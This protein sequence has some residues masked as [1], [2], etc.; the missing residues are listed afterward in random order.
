MA[1]LGLLYSVGLW[2]AGLNVALLIGNHCRTGQLRSLPRFCQRLAAGQY[3]DAGAD[4]GRVGSPTLGIRGFRIG[5]L[6]NAVLTPL[7]V[8]GDRIGL[9]PSGSHFCA[10]R[11][12]PSCSV[13]LA[14]WRHWPSPQFSRSDCG[15]RASAGC[16]VRCIGAAAA[17][18]RRRRLQH[19]QHR[20]IQPRPDG[21]AI[22]A[23]G[24]TRRRDHWEPS[25]YDP[26]K[27]MYVVCSLAG[28]LGLIVPPKPQQYK[29][30]ENV[31]RLR[32]GRLLRLQRRRL[33]HRLRHV[34]RQ[35]R[36]AEQIRR[37]NR[38][39]RAP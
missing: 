1:A 12:W 27:N 3:H 15:M 9:H 7:L 17:Q 21:S 16:E 10:A 38:A 11:R 25:S 34:D 35:N 13:S 26:E 6:E 18:C 36:L 30:G 39:T 29:E 37:K 23:V 22:A 19:C 31:H 2:I 5:L 33:R 20:P 28:S 8:G 4:T 24:A 32:H 14:Y